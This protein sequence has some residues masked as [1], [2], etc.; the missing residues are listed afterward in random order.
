LNNTTLSTVATTNQLAK[1]SLWHA[2]PY[3]G[4]VLVTLLIES[5]VVP[6]FLQPW[7]WEKSSLGRNRNNEQVF[8]TYTSSEEFDKIFRSLVSNQY[9]PSF[10]PNNSITNTVSHQFKNEHQDLFNFF[11]EIEDVEE[12]P[13]MTNLDNVLVLVTTVMNF[14]YYPNI[15]DFTVGVM[16]EVIDSLASEIPSDY[17]V[18]LKLEATL[19]TNCRSK[20]S[21][22]IEDFK[23]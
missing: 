4:T 6:N 11:N 15:E 10:S 20:L 13:E 17:L 22:I 5:D 8:N 9:Y 12:L 16:H 23:S 18:K 3:G 1:L 2:K 21:S 7:E 19:D 14:R